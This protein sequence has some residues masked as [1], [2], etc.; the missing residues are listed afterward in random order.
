ML[1]LIFVM[2]GREITRKNNLILYT[3]FT[4][5]FRKILVAKASVSIRIMTENKQF[6]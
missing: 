2:E 5:V 6:C 1:A 3:E 4:I